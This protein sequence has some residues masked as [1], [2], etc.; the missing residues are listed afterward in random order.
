MRPREQRLHAL[1]LL[2][3]LER[4]ERWSALGALARA[5]AEEASAR[6]ERIV[7]ERALTHPLPQAQRAWHLAAATAGG[8]RLA[9]ASVRQREARRALGSRELR[10][11]ALVALARDERSRLARACWR[12]ELADVLDDLAARER[13]RLSS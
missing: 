4:L 5:S 7:H 10:R 12:R 13:R 9:A 11:R 3:R 2:G 6:A 8:Q 1:V